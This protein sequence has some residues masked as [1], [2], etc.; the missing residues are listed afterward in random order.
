MAHLDITILGQQYKMGCPDGEE[1]S[2][3]QSVIQF[4]DKLKNMKET[5]P[6]R[7]NEQHIVTAALNYCHSLNI[8]RIKNEKYAQ[9]LN[10]RI[11]FLQDSIEQALT[12]TK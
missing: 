4:N 2:L 3:K 11:Q 1:E 9:E 5:A 10:K 8:E 7:R 12:P 6:G